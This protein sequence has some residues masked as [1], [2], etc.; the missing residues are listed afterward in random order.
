[1]DMVIV[2]SRL[3][4]GVTA[5]YHII[6]PTLLIGLSTFLSYLYIRWMRSDNHIY[7]DAYGLWLKVIVIVYIVAAITGVALSVQ[8]DH[9]FGGFYERVEDALVLVRQFELLFATILEGGC[10]G[11]MLL[12][13]RNPRSYRRLAATLLF[14]LGIFLTAFFVISRNS[15]MNTPAGFEWVD[16]HAVATN[17]LEILFNPSFIPR[18]LHMIMAGFMATSFFVLGLSAYKLRRNKN[19]HVMRKSLSLALSAGLIFSVAQFIIGDIHGLNTHENQP[20][21]IAAIEGQWESERG[22]GFKVFAM[23]DMANEENRA[24]VEIPYVASILLTHDINGEIRGLKEIPA[25]D[26]PNVPLVFYSFRIMIAMAMLMLATAIIGSWLKRRHRLVQTPWFLRLALW[27]M[28]AGL[29]AV[30]AGWVVAEVGR[31]PWVVYGLLRTSH[32]VTSESSDQVALSL[33]VFVV[34]YAILSIAT[35]FFLRRVLLTGDYFTKPGVRSGR[36]QAA[37]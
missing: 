26:R 16:G 35:V 3:Q 13:T 15:W 31:Q 28:P 25:Q 37:A 21:K 33:A 29:I 7:L 36:Q 19:D 30:I 8:L 27:T 12:C 34:G 24:V 4:F 11:V 20:M 1:M 5:G 23:P 17:H 14:N 22:A 32:V 10:I 6:F 2:L 9:V 18:Y